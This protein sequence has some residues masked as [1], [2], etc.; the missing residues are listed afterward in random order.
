MFEIV[1]IYI[2]WF[3]YAHVTLCTSYTEQA[4]HYLGICYLDATSSIKTRDT[5]THCSFL[6]LSSAFATLT[7][8]HKALCPCSTNPCCLGN[9]PDYPLCTT[10]WEVELGTQ[11][12][13]HQWSQIW[14]TDTYGSID[15]FW[16]QTTNLCYTGTWHRRDCL[17]VSK[18]PQTV[19][20]G[21]VDWLT[22]V[23]GVFKDKKDFG[24]GCTNCSI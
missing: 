3:N 13:A 9:T 7:L 4:L 6:L 17:S 23:V 18:A 12:E 16:R 20:F 24:Q 14:D 11:L 5:Q 2:F 22:R 8:W 10:Q 15:Y 19:A 21:D 1:T